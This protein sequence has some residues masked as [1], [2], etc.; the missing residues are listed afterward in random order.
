MRI[1]RLRQRGP[2]L[3][4]GVPRR[5]PG[6]ASTTTWWT[7]S[8]KRRRASSMG[9]PPTRPPSSGRVISADQRERVAGFV[10]R[11]VGGGAR[12]RRPAASRG[13]RRRLLLRA[14]ASSSTWTR[15]PRSSSGR[16]SARSSPCSASPTRPRRSP[17]R[18]TSTTASPPSCGP[19]TSAAPCASPTR[20]A[21]RHGL[22]QRPRPARVRDAARRVQAVG[23][24][25]GHVGLR[26]RGLDRAQARDDQPLLTR[27]PVSPGATAPC[28]AGADRSRCPPRSGGRRS[29]GPGGGPGGRV[30]R[31]SGR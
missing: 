12:R 22:G 29:R 15:T 13:R 11:A 27:P 4:R 2:G 16:C 28:G 17:G 23:L 6:R 14:D 31:T 26:H 9:D 10:D 8:P 18:T 3:H 20:P 30:A 21:V 24:R 5:S 7:G 1:V 19:A 25:Q